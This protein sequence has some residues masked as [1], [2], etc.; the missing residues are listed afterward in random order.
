[1]VQNVSNQV[2]VQNQSANSFGTISRVGTTN[3]GRVIYQ[4]VDGTG[5][6]AVK[7]S[8]A[9]KDCDSF[10]KSYNAIMENTPKLQEYMQKTPP[11]KMQKKQ[12][13]AKWIIAGLGLLG[14]ALGLFKT[15]GNGFWGTL[16]Q[17][18]VTALGTAAGLFTGAFIASKYVTP[19]GA[20]EFSKAT[21][22]ISKL[23][24]QAVQE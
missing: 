5:Q 17:I 18:G 6:K 22:T 14:G 24:I 11:E 8:V 4:I 20:A 1:M 2:A 3:N 23:D 7:M 19:P 15:K 10:E 9:Q 21:Q 16:K 13:R 12:K